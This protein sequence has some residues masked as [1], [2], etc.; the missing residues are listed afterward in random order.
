MTDKSDPQKEKVVRV[1]E[2]KKR[3]VGSL[4]IRLNSETM[5]EIGISEGEIVEIIGEGKK[6]SVAIARSAYPQDQDMGIIRLDSR[7]RENVGVDIDD[8]AR[9]RKAK[10]KMA[11]SIVLKPHDK[12]IKSNVRFESFVKRKLLTYPVTKDDLIRSLL[13]L[14]II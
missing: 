8:E 3:D 4:R 7:V 12:K 9:I 11:K 5:K 1:L 14:Y 6:S 2:A 13:Y 10:T